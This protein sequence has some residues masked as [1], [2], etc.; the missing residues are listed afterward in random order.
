VDTSSFLPA[1]SGDPRIFFLIN[2]MLHVQLERSRAARAAIVAMKGAESYKDITRLLAFTA[3]E[4]P[5]SLLVTA[6]PINSSEEELWLV[7]VAERAILSVT[8]VN[9][10]SSIG[11]RDEFFRAYRAPRCLVGGTSCIVLSSDSESMYIDVETKRGDSPT[12][13]QPLGDVDARDAAW[14]SQDG[15]SLYLLLGCPPE[16]ALM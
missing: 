10:P 2:G 12:Q 5:L 1:P 3:A 4:S 8:R 16:A 13:L 7:T 14:A 11:N 15:S 9:T 6:R